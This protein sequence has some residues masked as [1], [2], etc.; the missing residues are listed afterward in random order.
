MATIIKYPKKND[1]L[2]MLQ[3]EENIRMSQYYIDM[4]D[5]VKDE[6]NGWLRVSEEIQHEIAK[7][8]GYISDI[9]RNFAVNRMRRAQ[10]IYP[11]EPLFKTIPVYVRN[12]LARR[13][14]FS[15]GDLVPNILIF[16]E[17]K[18]HVNLFD[19]FRHDK[20]NLLFASSQT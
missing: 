12:N 9:E 8:F 13:G 15:T 17:D 20:T 16:D 10:Y 5:E 6:V 19:L 3:E 14:D 1:L 11:D 18:N 7:K 4:C 2:K